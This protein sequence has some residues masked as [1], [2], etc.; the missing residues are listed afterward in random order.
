[1]AEFLRSPSQLMPAAATL[2][3]LYAVPAGF[4]AV[5][6][7]INVCNQ[8]SAEDRFRISIAVGGAADDLKQY[9]MYDVTIDGNDSIPITCGWTLSAGDVVRVR[10]LNGACSFNL[11][12]LER[13]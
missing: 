1:M 10:S 9:E 8:S 13:N 6:S 7:T 11:F 2:T 5:V 12:K 3:N 4:T